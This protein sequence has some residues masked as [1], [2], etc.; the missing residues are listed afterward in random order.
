MEKYRVIRIHMINGL[1]VI[2]GACLVFMFLTVWTK[3]I[4]YMD[5]KGNSTRLDIQKGIIFKQQ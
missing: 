5:G 2:G 3:N 1:A 4:V